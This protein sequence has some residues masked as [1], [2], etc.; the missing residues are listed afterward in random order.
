[1]KGKSCFKNI[2]STAGYQ[3]GRAISRY[4]GSQIQIQ[5]KPSKFCFG[6][7]TWFSYNRSLGCYLMIICEKIL[8]LDR[9]KRIHSSTLN[10]HWVVAFRGANGLDPRVGKGI[11]PSVFLLPTI[12]YVNSPFSDGNQGTPHAPPPPHTARFGLPLLTPNIVE[13]WWWVNWDFSLLVTEK[14]TETVKDFLYPSL[15]PS[16]T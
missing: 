2:C 7:R 13:D 1:M 4:L 3:S 16:A 5:A 15:T 9:N 8:A 11:N 12:T 10:L 14:Y 6:K